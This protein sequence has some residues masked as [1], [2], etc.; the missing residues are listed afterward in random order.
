VKA[1]VLVTR[2]FDLDGLR[3]LWD[4]CEVVYNDQ[5]APLSREDLI[6]GVSE[7]D[8]LLCTVTDRVDEEVLR[9]AGRLRVISTVSVGYDHVDVAA[10]TRLRIPVTNTPDVLTETTADL[11][12]ALILAA[13]R[14]IAEGDR[15]VR[16]GLFQRW[17]FLEFLGTDVHGK[18]LGIVGMG[19]IG[20]AV[21]RRA[22]GF[23]MRVL[24]NRRSRLSAE[25]EVALKA[26]YADLEFLLS[27]SDFI[28]IHVPLNRETHHM[29]SDR[30]LRM[31][32]PTAILINASRGAVVDE[33][34]LCRALETGRIAGAG[35]DVYERE[36]LVTPGLL[37]LPQVVLAPH[38]GS[39]TVET[40][41]RMTERA[42]HNCL[43]TLEGRV[44]PDLLNPEVLSPD[45]PTR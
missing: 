5:D 25:Q 3:P 2:R 23:A 44:P 11:T 35:L 43:E 20:M 9:A 42:V 1:R 37:K 30:E 41:R 29:I 34:A 40:R 32:K 31:M 26:E 36:P 13:A 8:A 18:V 15:R 33:E 28:T 7:A 38:V 12:W 16:E 39:A 24:Y 10:A 19:R 27:A 17:G 21:A 45:G 22:S 14:R 6:E 4:S